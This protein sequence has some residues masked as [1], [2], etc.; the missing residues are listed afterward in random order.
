M[1][2]LENPERDEPE[3]MNWIEDSTGLRYDHKV[4]LS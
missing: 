3:S 2:D 1:S 4:P